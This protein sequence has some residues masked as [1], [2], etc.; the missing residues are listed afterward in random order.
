MQ[1]N[2]N[3]KVNY[4]FMFIRNFSVTQGIWMLYLAARGMTLLE[5]GLLEGIF[6]I[7]S[8]VME[9]PT[10][11]VADIFGRKASRLIG[12]ALAV[13]SAALMIISDGF[14][15]FALSFVVSA[16]SYN[17][18][19]GAGEALVYDSLLMD[20]RESAYMK[21]T[22]LT[23][24]IYQSAG[25]AAL[26]LGGLIGN[27]RYEFAYYAAIVLAVASLLTGT[28]MKE[29]TVERQRHANLAQALKRQ[30]VDSFAALRGSTRLKYLLFV[31]P[32][33]SAS[34]TLSF[35]Y[36][37]IAWENAQASTLT[38]GLYL[39]ASS[40]AAAAGAIFAHRIERWLG[41]RV[42][43]AALPM[44][45]ALLIFGLR[46][47]ALSLYAF[48][49]LNAI[50]AVLYVVTRAYLN[51]IIPSAQR[52]TILSLESTLFSLMM[53]LLFPLFGAISD[54]LTVP[55]A[56]LLLGG[57]MTALAVGN[58]WVGLRQHHAMKD[59]AGGE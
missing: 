55:V 31:M 47:P 23:E 12:C 6:H 25:I 44:A 14:A 30:Y 54:R 50:E 41:G 38:I 19:S 28:L 5:I 35:Y 57:V 32:V 22:G 15:L 52:A 11:A 13:L 53:I 24:V 16:L 56:F 4:A 20:G 26:A 46:F 42:L 1:Y 7:T 21:I 48:C 9:T 39:A 51:R 8:L 27:I 10:G 3:I 18:E 45:V 29:P 37:Q 17:F 43:L 34:V 59:M 2:K 40:V 33:F 58:V 36:M 49:L